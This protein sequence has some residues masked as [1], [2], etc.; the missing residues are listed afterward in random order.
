MLKICLV[1]DEDKEAERLS[2]AIRRYMQEK[3]L[4][5]RVTRFSDGQDFVDGYTPGY[6]IVFL[7]IVL[8]RCNG[9]KAARA[10]RS[11]DGAV[12]L[13]FV[14]NMANMAVKGY[15]VEASDFIVKPVRYSSFAMKMDRILAARRGRSAS[16]LIAAEGNLKVLPASSVAYIE[17][18]GHNLVYHTEQGNIVTRG[19]LSKAEEQVKGAGFERCN[20]CYL[21]NLAFV[22]AVEGDIVTVGGDKLHISRAKKKSFLEKLTSSFGQGK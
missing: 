20:V 16:L 9:M 10:L 18:C 7:D 4:Q 13:V 12:S 14:T 1:E 17:V 22:T 6:D 11:R 3:D 5:Y 2:A 21:V 8:P 19:A 15:E